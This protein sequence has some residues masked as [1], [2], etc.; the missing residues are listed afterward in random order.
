MKRIRMVVLFICLAALGLALLSCRLPLPDVNVIQE[1]IGKKTPTTAI[2]T[3]PAISTPE[4]SSG[5]EEEA[6]YYMWASQPLPDITQDLQ[7][8]F[9]DAGYPDIQ[10][11]AG[12]F[13]ENCVRQD[14][15]V[16]GFH[17]MYTDIFIT[18]SVD[19]LEDEQ[20]LAEQVEMIMRLALDYPA[21]KLPGSTEGYLGISLVNPQG[22][23]ENLWFRRIDGKSALDRGLTGIELLSELRGK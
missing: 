15:S 16:A 18:V 14:G 20:S 2:Q 5:T 6:C 23:P 3:L 11:T 17:T 19:Q 8:Y 21:E 7:K 12:A 22:Q 10:A 9:L 1:W 13:G 4:I